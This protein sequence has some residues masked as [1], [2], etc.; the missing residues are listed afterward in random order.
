MCSVVRGMGKSRLKAIWESHLELVGIEERVGAGPVEG[1][2]TGVFQE[3]EWQVQG[4]EWKDGSRNRGMA[5]EWFQR[6]MENR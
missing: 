5:E 1:L 2:C 6:K 4:P 3:E